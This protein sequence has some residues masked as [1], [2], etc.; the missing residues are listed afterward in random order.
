[1]KDKKAIRTKRIIQIAAVCAIVTGAVLFVRSRALALFNPD[2]AMRYS[3]FSSTHT[4]DNS[5]LFI[6]TYLI[7]IGAMTDDLY[8]KAMN[9]AS[10]SNQTSIYYKSELA[11]GAWFDVTDSETLTDIMNGA[12]SVPESELADLYVQYY[13]GADGTV[14]NVKDEDINPFDIPDPYKLSQ[15]KELEPLWLQYTSSSEANDIDQAGYL[16]NK[17]SDNTGNKRTDVYNYQL[18]STFFAM[19]LRDEETDGYDADLARLYEAYKSYKAAGQDEEADIIYNLMAKVDASRRAVV[20]D[21]LAVMDLNALDVLNDL[22]NGRYYTVSG[23]FLDPDSASEK[24]D[25][26]GE[27]DDDFNDISEDPDYIVE[28]KESVQHDFEKGDEDEDEWWNPLQKDYEKDLDTASGNGSP[29][30]ADSALTDAIGDCI[31]NCNQSYNDYQAKALTDSDTVLGHAEYEYSVEVTEQASA[32]GAGGPIVMLRDVLNIKENVIKHADSEKNLLDTSLLDLAEGDY[33]EVLTAGEPTGYQTMLNSGAGSAAADTMLNDAMDEAEAK[34]SELEYLI[35]AYRQR[36][37]AAKALTYVNGCISWTNG[38]Y[39]E[40]GEDDFKVKADGSIDSH[41]KWLT[42]LAEQIKKSDDSLKSKLDQLNDKKAELQGKRDAA[43]DDNDLA[44]AKAYDKMIEAVDQDI[45]EE[46]KNTGK[47]SDDDLAKDIANDA[48][49]KLADDPKADVSA[50]T[51][52]LA[53]MGKADAAAEVAAKAGKG[54]GSGSGDDSGK[55]S[56]DDES[57]ILSAIAGMFG[58]SIDELSADELAIVTAAVSRYGRSGNRTAVQ[59]AAGWAELM[60]SKDSKYLYS[61]YEAKTPRYI[62]LKTIGMCTPYR[63]YYDDSRKT[64]TMTSG[65]KACI[66]KTGSDV[67][68]RG[69]SAEQ[70]KYSTVISRYPYISEDDATDL[71]DCHCEYVGS[72]SYGVCLTGA[73]EGK[74]KELLD[75]LTGDDSGN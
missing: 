56:K 13:V 14:K 61:Q 8:D 16:N 46:E 69:G 37:E 3:E 63:Y 53:G 12:E 2:D 57:D 52:A 20:M 58:K 66:F 29:H 45:A 32:G 27:E 23:N 55:G 26:D 17:N 72:S 44:G 10:E 70:L 67:L 4:I 36:E 21:K 71:F 38:L 24:N 64:A 47:S 34:R 65:S 51:D 33:E 49:A 1:M 15:L 18:L 19:D 6:G 62:S 60:R 30:N 59:L 35:D 5:T 54:S 50:A 73:M 22:A 31:Q 41:I 11:D 25:D 42:D 75:A 68:S 74:A 48:K 7:N 39:D 9:S 28:L 43:L 40:V